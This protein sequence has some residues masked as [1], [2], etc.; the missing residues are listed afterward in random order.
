VRGELELSDRSPQDER[1]GARDLCQEHGPSLQDSALTDVVPL[2][3][4][5]A[6]RWEVCQR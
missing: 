5:A 3:L 4:L 6:P 1:R 2:A